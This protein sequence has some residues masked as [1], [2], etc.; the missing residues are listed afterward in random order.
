MT[1]YQIDQID[2]LLLAEETLIYFGASHDAQAPKTD[3]QLRLHQT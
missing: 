3:T 1:V 2:S